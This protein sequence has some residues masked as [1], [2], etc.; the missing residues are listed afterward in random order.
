MKI[1]ETIQSVKKAVK[2]ARNRGKT[3]GLVPTMG[4]L[5]IGHIS[6]I[7]QAKKKTDFVVVSIFVTPPQFGPAEDFEK[8]PR[9]L[10][11]DL[12]I[13]RKTGVDL[14]FAPDTKQMYPDENLTWVDVEKL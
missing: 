5:H 3:I 2:T 9:P 13:G 1:A 4:A 6:L 11:D 10:K 14:V 12:K 7:E 8:Y